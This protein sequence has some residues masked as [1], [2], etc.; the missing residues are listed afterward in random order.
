MVNEKRAL[1]LSHTV[2]EKYVKFVVAHRAQEMID[3]RWATKEGRLWMG[4]GTV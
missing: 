2:Y 3:L 4:D 1:F